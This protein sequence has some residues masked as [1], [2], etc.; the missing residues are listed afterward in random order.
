MNMVAHDWGWC[1]A[2]G[3]CSLSPV[4]N[5]ERNIGDLARQTFGESVKKYRYA[6]GW[7]QEHLARAMTANGVN[8]T[9]TMVAKI[10]RGDRPTSISEAAVIAATFS[11]PVQALLPLDRESATASHLGSL[12]TRFQTMLGT[13]K[14]LRLE[15]SEYEDDMEALL[16][17]WD[18]YVDGITDAEREHLKSMDID[19]RPSSEN[20]MRRNVNGEHSEEA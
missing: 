5:T 8:A 7:T 12:L 11:I 4:E 13:L 3:E 9:Q 17:Q 15:V 16:D 1:Q 6:N 2:L 20:G 14:N 18:E 19:A 10:E